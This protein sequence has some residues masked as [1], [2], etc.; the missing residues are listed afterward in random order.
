MFTTEGEG[1]FTATCG[2][3]D[4]GTWNLSTCSY[5]VCK[6][7]EVDTETVDK[8]RKMKNQNESLGA[9]NFEYAVENVGY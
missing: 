7:V 1:R 9:E 4:G 8:M 5:P 6:E 2:E 3:K